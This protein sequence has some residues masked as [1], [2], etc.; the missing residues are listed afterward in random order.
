MPYFHEIV[1]KLE[2]EEADAKRRQCGQDLRGSLVAQLAERRREVTDR[3]LHQEMSVFIEHNEHVMR[4]NTFIS[5][6]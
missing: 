4:F 5:N 6:I 3:I 2:N 1:H